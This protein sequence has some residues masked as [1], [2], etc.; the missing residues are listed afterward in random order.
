MVMGEVGDIR[1]YMVTALLSLAGTVM[2]EIFHEADINVVGQHGYG[3]S[4]TN[5]IFHRAKVTVVGWL[6]DGRGRGI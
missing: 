6:G 2:C 5:N 4:L 3:R 1:Y